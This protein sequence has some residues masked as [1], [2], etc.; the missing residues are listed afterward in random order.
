MKKYLYKLIILAFPLFFTACE[1]ND[2]SV[3][4]LKIINEQELSLFSEFP[5]QKNIIVSDKAG[6]NV[7]IKVLGKNKTIIESLDNN[8]FQLFAIFDNSSKLMETEK[9]LEMEKLPLI[10]NSFSVREDDFIFHVHGYSLKPGISGFKVKLNENLNQKNSSWELTYHIGSNVCAMKFLY[11]EASCSNEY[12]IG[13]IYGYT[14]NYS[15]DAQLDI[16]D[17]FPLYNTGARYVDVSQYNYQTYITLFKL[18][19]SCGESYSVTTS[20]IHCNN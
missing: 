2:D 7:K 9:L 12:M 11:Q 5:L 16:L 18:V 3:L 6:N 20:P 10:D 4:G 1:K 15:W 14:Q 8:S 13:K 19:N 17:N